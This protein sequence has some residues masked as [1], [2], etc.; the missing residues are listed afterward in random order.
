MK[1][2]VK[3]TLSALLAFLMLFQASQ[4]GV[5][6]AAEENNRTLDPAE[7]IQLT[8][9]ERFQDGGNWFF[10]PQQ[11]Y[12]ASEK[13]KEKIYIPIQ[14]SGD[15][16]AE[17]DVV[18]KITDI[19]AKHDVNYKAELY[20]D[21]TEPETFLGDVSLVE[22][23]HNADLQEEFE[24]L[25]DENELGEIINAA[26]GA[27]ILDG[28]GNVVGT[29]T[30]T[31]VDGS[32]SAIPEPEDG[33]TAAEEAPQETPKAEDAEPAAPGAVEETDWTD[34]DLS[35]TEALRAARDA[36]TGTVSD[37]QELAGGDL[38]DFN[39]AD[40]T[41]AMTDEEF[42]QTMADA[43]VEDY[44]G[45][46]YT[47]HFAAGEEAKFLVI[48]PLYSN[49]AEGDAQ[50][51]LLLKDPSENFA[52]GEDVNPVSV[53][54]FDEDEPEPVTVSM[55]A[56]TVTAENGKAA[57]TVTRQGRLNAIKG[58]TLSSWD[59]TA[60]Q[61]D[62]YSGVGAKL[63]FPVGITSRTVEIPVYHGTEEKDFYVSIT[64]LDDETVETATTRVIIP[65]AGSDAG[66]GEL[67]GI[68]DANGHP[69]TNPI[70]I[71]AGSYD[72]GEF[73]SDTAFKL[74]TR[75][76]KEETAHF[77]LDPTVYG[78]AYDGI[79]LDYTCWTSWCDIECRLVRWPG[80]GWTRVHTNA[81]DNDKEGG[82]HWLYSAWNAVKPTG[83]Y[84]IELA[85]VNKKGPA[86]TSSH[87][88]M[89]V[90]GVRLIKRQFTISVKPAEV[91]P[92]LGMKDA[93]VLEKY[94][95]VFLDNSI[96]SSRTLWTDD[97]F[98]VSSTLTDGPL[99]LVGLEA[100]NP[101]TNKWV[102][103][104][105]ID[106]KSQTANVTMNMATVND[107][108]SKGLFTWSKNGSTNGGDFY[109]GTLTVR[110]V[111]EYQNAT[112]ELQ[113]D[114]NG[115]LYMTAPTPN[116]LWD[117]NADNAMN[118]HMGSNWQQQ[119]SWKGEKSG[120]DDY[121]TFTA[122]G[123][124]P[125]VSMDT[126]MLRA[127]EVKW[128][129][130]RAKN[131]GNAR[132][133][134]LFASVGD[135]GQNI[136]STNVQINLASDSQ[137]HEY[138]VE[139]TNK[140]WKDNIKWLRL[141]PMDRHNPDDRM[142][143][144]QKIQIDYV[145]FFSD[146][147]S[148]RAFRSLSEPSLLWDFNYGE[149]LN[150]K[151]GANWKQGV[152]WQGM[153]NGS[154]EYYTFYALGSDPFVSMDTPV[155]K[156]S[157]V[158]WV[159]IRAKNYS[160]ISKMQL[161]ASVGDAG[162][163][164]GST[165]VDIPIQTDWGEWH[166]Y[167][168]EIKNANWKDDIKWFRLD[169]LDGSRLWDQICIDYIAF[170]PDEAGARAFRSD[171][172]TPG[173]DWSG[174]VHGAGP[175]TYHLGD[176]PAFRTVVSSL[177]ESNNLKEDGV[178]FQIRQLGKT[179]KVKDWSDSH[180]LD[181]DNG[182]TL[183]GAGLNIHNVVDQPYYTFKPTFTEKGN[184][185]TVEITKAALAYFDTTQGIF[186]SGN[187]VKRTESGD[188]WIYTIQEN[189][190]SNVVTDLEATPKSSKNFTAWTRSGETD[191]TFGNF[192]SF[193]TGQ[194]TASNR[195]KLEVLVNGVLMADD[196]EDGVLMALPE[197]FGPTYAAITG[198]VATS[199][200]NLSRERS[201]KDALP[202]QYAYVAYGNVGT[203]TDEDGH[204]ELPPIYAMGGGML[205]YTVTYN[206][207]V[208][209]QT[210]KIP[211]PNAPKTD[212]VTME[213]QAVQAVTANPG[214]VRVEAFSEEGAHFDTVSFTQ[215]GMLGGAINA[216]F[217]NGK[218][219]TVTV[220]V[221]QGQDYQL[222]G[223]T[224][225]EH[226]K[227]V[228]LYFM[229]QTTGQVHG[230]FSSNETPSANS[231]AKWSYDDST[232]DFTL[233]ITQFD[234]THPE[235][236]TYGD[237]L[238]ARLTTDKL[239]G[240][241]AWTQEQGQ[242]TAWDEATGKW[243]AV[244]VKEA[245]VYMVYEPVSTGIA[246]AA[247]PDYTPQTFDFKLENIAGQLGVVPQTDGDG[248][249]LDDDTEY[250]F[251]SF[252]YIGEIT[253]GIRVFSKLVNTIAASRDMDALMSDVDFM[254]SG[255]NGDD[256]SYAD[257]INSGSKDKM[258]WGV[259]VVFKVEE[260]A[261]GNVRFLFGAILSG[262]KGY[263]RQRNP[264][265]SV[266]TLI[267][268]FS[269]AE[270]GNVAAGIIM[271]GINAHKTGITTSLSQGEMSDFGGAHFSFGA[272]LGFY[273]DYGYVE[274]STNG[275]T[276]KS[277][278]MVF[279][280]AGGFIG[281]TG[282]IG[283]TV[284]FMAGPVPMYF[285]GDAGLLVSFFFGSA[286]D[287][288]KT[289]E[290]FKTDP[291]LHGQDFSF[292]FEFH[293]RFYISATLGVGFY[294]ILGVRVT[295]TLAFEA[296][297][298]SNIT[299]WYPSLFDSGW[300][301]VTEATF[302]GTIDLVV[303]SIDLYSATWPLPLSGGFLYYFQE[304]RRANKCI[305]YVEKAIEKGEGS[306]S[307]RNTAQAMCDE[308][309]QLVDA[310]ELQ[311]AAESKPQLAGTDTI[312]DKTYA[313]RDY[314]WD[315]DIINW[316]TYNAIHM[317]SQGGLIGTIINATTEDDEGEGLR[318]HTNDHVDP[319]WVAGEGQLMAGYG[320]VSSTA[321]MED[322]YANPSSKI[323]SIGGG[324]YLMVFLDDT[325][326][327]DRM[328]AATLKW[329]VYNANT[330]TW[331]EPKTVQNDSTVDSRP[332]LT[333]AG[334]KVILSWASAADEKYEALKSEVAGELKAKTGAEPTADQIQTALE[335][336]PAR[337]LAILDIFT[338]EF[339]KSSET[340]GSI[341]Q[342]TDDEDYDDY[343]QAV[344]DSATG[345]YIVMY[346]KTAQDEED[347]SNSGDKLQD[348]MG[349]SPDPE[350]TY[351]IIAYMLYN[352][353]TGAAD[354]NGQTHEP[355][356]AKD[357][358]F[359]NE[360]SQSLEDQAKSLERFGGQRFLPST[361]RTEEGK[362]ADPPITDLTV[363]PGYDGMAAYAF[364]VDRDFDL[365][366]AEDRELYVEF[367]NFANHRTYVPVKVA[368]EITVEQEK[369][370]SALDDFVTYTSQKAVEVGTPKLIRNGGDTYLFWREDGQSLKYLNISEMLQAK[371]AA[372][373][374]PNK[375]T[376]GDWTWAVKSD[377]TYATDAATGETYEPAVMR[378]DFGSMLTDDA[379]EIT[380]YEVISD[381]E[382][383][384][385][386]VWTD[387]VTNTVTDAAGE[388]YPVAAQEIYASGMVHQEE[389]TS[390]GTDENGE[391][392]SDTSQTVRWSKPY[393]L[394]RDN[395]F[396]DGL[397][398]AVDPE[399]DL[400]IVHNQ[401]TKETAQSEA[402]VYRLIDEGK[403]G[404]TKDREGNLYAASLSY[405]S[406]VR[407]MVTQFEKT[408]SLEATEFTFSD[409][410]PV[411]GETIVV[412]AAIENVGL[413]DAQGSKIDFYE[414]KD[415]VQGKLIRSFES[416]DSIPVNTAKAL[417]FLWTIPEDGPEGYSVKA[418]IAEQKSPGEYYPGTAS[419][420][421]AF[422]EMPS[423][424]VAATEA[425][426]EG[427]QFRVAFTASNTGNLDAPQGT[428]VSVRLEGLYGDLNS[429]RYGN[430]ETE[431]LY[432]QDITSSLGAKTLAE[433][434]ELDAHAIPQSA[435]YEGDVLVDI[436]ASVFRYCGYDAVRIVLTD[437]SGSVLAESDQLLVT[438]DTPVNL[439][440][441]DGKSVK[442]Q[443]GESQQVSLGFD[444]TV[445]MEEGTV[446]YSV[447]DP[448][449]AVVDEQG[450][451]TGV[452]N[453]NTVL[454]ATLLPSGRTVKTMI[455]VEDK[456][457]MESF[458]DLNKNGWYHDGVHW[459]LENSVMN[460]VGGAKFNPDG[461]TS[462]AMIVTML[463]R[464]EGEPEVTSGNTFSD[465]PNGTWYTKAVTWAQANGIV[466]GVGNNK[467]AP[468]ADLTREQ[469]VTILQRYVAYKDIDTSAGE[470]AE[471][472]GYS[473][474]DAIAEWAAPAF[475]WAVD[476]GII[477]GTGNGKLSPKTNASRAQVATMLMR[478][479]VMS[480]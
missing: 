129:K 135:A 341:T 167:V 472:V 92:L 177:G 264:Y 480:K 28:E 89:N 155:A 145:A 73:K 440:L 7:Q 112:V 139:I 133:M 85:D 372:V 422:E 202:A 134:E 343:P 184:C 237:V 33:E 119:V 174:E 31:P 245:P 59:G 110:P 390:T 411:A 87:A 43:V 391:T 326:S 226:V 198:T 362:Y 439:S 137:W 404:V 338:V 425:V 278:D 148:A 318:Y 86:G 9:P 308:L 443:E 247:D 457:P 199:T 410:Y 104:V 201:A 311:A 136:G 395:A 77:W 313:L 69:F 228:T 234:P 130:I 367:Y 76:N 324:K 307:A 400:L 369:Y 72:L 196:A 363:A 254:A 138:V 417:R 10:I 214:V 281:F 41:S 221:A 18:L 368:G 449:I 113:Q 88:N 142:T 253:A 45:K 421:A 206:G 66:D 468:T 312:K 424:R 54:I 37:R 340:F 230:T 282:G 170:F 82:D 200:F 316:T 383:N 298:G 378:V 152:T 218:Q 364:T 452:A 408:G 127:D 36:Y 111:F 190:N 168:V 334:D 279:M 405:N 289:L 195:V 444:A 406:P 48:T 415:G 122:E 115:E 15:V 172:A 294:K 96:K 74:Y 331:T 476:A 352:N 360:T 442:V 17:A 252:P 304:M 175:F 244:P 376:A 84:S 359:P 159:K 327:R 208:S 458:T 215:E 413:T 429:D 356:W 146:E 219:L 121:Y 436:P 392:V 477:N 423:Y 47:L 158:R 154:D 302:T 39:A 455:F 186:K 471:L 227:D 310:S 63:Y 235:S 160:K 277:H 19:S 426:Q 345:D 430:L 420:S 450:K 6:L 251:G 473:D 349:V 447:A 434:T 262:G 101:T 233:R 260:T 401:Y 469:L 255:N 81:W 53:T 212:K 124:D 49:A 132:Q 384:L 479:D 428:T 445:F 123:K 346:Y 321:L 328:Q 185:V 388:T 11:G 75:S 236:W 293:G 3:R 114:P 276:E 13:S 90:S 22:L 107:L 266:D 126:P 20:K 100:L 204:F 14:R 414:C 55:A 181:D 207:S 259:N 409:E 5:A 386:V 399:G 263:E 71:K 21:P 26:G 366:T 370:D 314:A 275:G 319:S 407:L 216:M 339:N 416:S 287:P 30:A 256:L 344:Y 470:A 144:G 162:K 243:T 453:G 210:V 78:A 205:T 120:N 165:Q 419:T 27:E 153:K 65:A 242:R 268:E 257:P 297:Y 194:R 40:L 248:K 348:I 317:N 295:V 103:I 147:N 232:G 16:S 125:F 42:D 347:Y 462:R 150:S 211:G 106:G 332:S 273:L 427:D 431:V 187:Y 178:T 474:V 456:C 222:N 70:N 105:T 288:A 284:A 250:S 79:Y 433:K 435:V 240:I 258:S 179:G 461:T 309:K 238:M 296:G 418:V 353:Q 460:G 94:Q 379:I 437:K 246:V 270:L 56:E 291:E 463:Y 61:G 91:K 261:F 35:S 46:E 371:V 315:H 44:P 280:G 50:L 1:R 475:R 209:I 375:D 335:K 380:D 203:W 271:A 23:V 377:G 337:V 116:L 117:F 467:F 57:I 141:D 373:A 118:S 58:V 382:D 330:D 191:P 32:G 229:D 156:A 173:S 182:V 333:D 223:V 325:A 354:T 241:S 29:V 381:E 239:V 99:L 323:L 396:N 446:V 342:L 451:V 38:T 67:M 68:S 365:K 389:K 149:A 285:N 465:V 83:K 357:Y 4:G 213:G 64:A 441:N 169:P 454:T 24:P 329:T 322:A 225:Q 157:D 62:E 231:P 12:T 397:A 193:R 60:A 292:N 299:D 8:V 387:T 2:F 97:A 166:E 197:G 164:I 303:T 163:A 393:R 51:I 108:E 290:S 140:N 301:Y 217:M 189:V 188:S 131:L 432:S 374:E 183:T 403:I 438:M 34:G 192:Y 351:S 350:K 80:S 272:F 283:Y 306:A 320:A 249:L 151:M 143:S 394:T 398:L 361:I 355:G 52:I 269:F 478:F 109:K 300:G 464:M 224:H 265:Q 95:S 267:N 93:D 274:I 25:A 412:S 161:Y 358:Y 180:Y 171:S 220:N 102:R 402:E 459:A 448:G 385:Y 336:D 305:E 128:V 466:N 286:G 98:S 176:T